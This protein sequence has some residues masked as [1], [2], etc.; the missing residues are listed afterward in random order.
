MTARLGIATWLLSD[1]PPSGNLGSEPCTDRQRK[2]PEKGPLH[3]QPEETS[4][5]HLMEGWGREACP[6]K[7]PGKTE[8]KC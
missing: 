3:G 7:A 8:T 2:N 6:G 1:P 4:R 5:G